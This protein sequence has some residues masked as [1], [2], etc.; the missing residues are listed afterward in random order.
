MIPR[1]PQVYEFLVKAFNFLR[2]SEIYYNLFKE[3]KL[4]KSER[5][6]KNLGR[7]LQSSSFSKNAQ[8]WG[9]KKCNLK[10]CG[11]C[12]YLMEKERVYFDT[13]DKNF[14]I[15]SQLIVTVETLF[16][17]FSVQGAINSILAIL[18]T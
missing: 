15:K 16:M 7:L 11:T 18:V 5:Q 1:N 9:V 12:P 2:S 14:I 6:P 17:Q 10:R 8:K 3:V 13:V 4:I